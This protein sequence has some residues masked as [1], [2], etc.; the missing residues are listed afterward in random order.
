MRCEVQSEIYELRQNLNRFWSVKT[1]ESLGNRVMHQF[2]RDIKHNG[3][4]YITKLP[5][6]TDH[7]FLPDNYNTYKKRLANLKIKLNDKKL[8]TECNQFFIEYEKKNIIERVSESDIFKEPGCV[9]YLLHR[10]V[11]H[12]DK[13][14]T[15]IRGVFDASCSTTGPSLND[16]L[17][18]GPNLLTKI[19]NI[20]LKLRFNAVVVIADKKQAFLNIKISFEHRDY[21]RLIWHEKISDKKDKL[22]VYRFLRA[23]FGLTCN[24]FLL[25]ATLKHHLNK[26][27]KNDKKFIKRLID[28]LYLDDIAYDCES[29][30]EGKMFYKK[31]KGTFFRRSF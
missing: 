17:H 8:V 29:V 28:D 23:V 19:F 22:I 12:R 15:K 13:D 18:S 30:L 31:S 5:F 3:E 2:K 10:P 21:M 25:N 11:I 26:Y 20:L 7:D 14:T 16:C 1:I 4:R 6:K 24:T 27:F 9:H